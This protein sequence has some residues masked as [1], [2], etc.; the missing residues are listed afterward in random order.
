MTRFKPSS[1][2]AQ[3]EFA[4]ALGHSEIAPQAVLA[5]HYLARGVFQTSPRKSSQDSSCFHTP[6]HPAELKM[7]KV[8]GAKGCSEQTVSQEMLRCVHSLPVMVQDHTACLRTHCYVIR[9]GQVMRVTHG[10]ITQVS[11]WK[12]EIL[13]KSYL[14]RR[15]NQD[16]VCAYS[17]EQGC[18]EQVSA[19]LFRKGP[20]GKQF[21]L[22]HLFCH[23]YPPLRR[24]SGNSQ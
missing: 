18:P 5:E 12:S 24:E 3:A 20:G 1:S 11:A 19:N 8:L 14:V 23:N 21:R 10:C 13:L 6:V 17:P 16:C 9:Q 15:Q 7:L 22:C 4:S 2:G